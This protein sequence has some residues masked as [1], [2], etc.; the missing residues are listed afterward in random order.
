MNKIIG[1]IEDSS[2]KVI[3][4]MKAAGEQGIQGIQGIQGEQGD[5]G[6]TPIKGVDYFDGEKGDKGDKGDTGEQGEQGIQGD[7]GA[8]V[9]LGTFSNETQ[10]ITHVI[11][12][13]LPTGHYTFFIEGYPTFMLLRKW[14]NYYTGTFNNSH[15]QFFYFHVSIYGEMEEAKTIDLRDLM[16]DVSV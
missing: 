3:V 4:E 6:Y 10:L 1:T 9:D 5:D 14:T 16:T 15:S 7:D 12:N 8:I 11:M 13:Q 2:M